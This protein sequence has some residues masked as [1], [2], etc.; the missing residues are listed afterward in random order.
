MLGSLGH[1]TSEAYNLL[2]LKLCGCLF[3]DL[4]HLWGIQYVDLIKLTFDLDILLYSLSIMVLCV[5]H[6]SAECEIHVAFHSKVMA[7]LLC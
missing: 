1:C 3:A 7:H 5:L 2:S 4:V 6:T